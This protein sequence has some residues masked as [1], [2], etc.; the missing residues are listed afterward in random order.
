M[1][2]VSFLWICM[3]LIPTIENKRKDLWKKRLKEL[4]FKNQP[5]KQH[6]SNGLLMFKI[7]ESKS[8]V[9]VCIGMVGSHFT[10][11]MQ[12]KTGTLSAI[13]IIVSIID[14]RLFWIFQSYKQV[15]HTYFRIY[16]YICLAC[17]SCLYLLS[18]I[19]GNECN[20]KCWLKQLCFQDNYDI[21][22]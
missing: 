3:N 11:K 18:L 8:S 1:G 2:I 9:R 4:Y 21:K 22:I 16:H 7:T 10:I 17:N 6:F 19:S 14:Y 12:S 15:S 20:F 13:A 5:T